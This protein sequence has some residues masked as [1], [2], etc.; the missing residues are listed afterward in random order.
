M[1]VPQATVRPE[2][3]PRPGDV[4]VNKFRSDA[5]YQ[6]DLKAH[7]DA[8]GVTD[9]VVTGYRSQYCVESTVRRAMDLGDSITFAA[10]GHGPSD[11]GGLQGNRMS[12]MSQ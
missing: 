11:E 7:L 6:T 4:V 5:F 8:R 9:L 12:F 2:V 3:A 10:D 1:A